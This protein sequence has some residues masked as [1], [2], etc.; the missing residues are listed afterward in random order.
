MTENSHVCKRA[1]SGA[2]HPVRRTSSM[3]SRWRLIGRIIELCDLRFGQ[4]HGWSQWAA[5]RRS[6]MSHSSPF[7]RT[8]IRYPRC[9]FRDPS[10]P[11]YRGRRAAR[12]PI[13]SATQPSPHW[14]RSMSFQTWRRTPKLRPKPRRRRGLWPEAKSSLLHLTRTANVIRSAWNGCA[15]DR[16]SNRPNVSTN[17]LR[18]EKLRPQLLELMKTMDP[19]AQAPAPEVSNRL[20]DAK[21]TIEAPGAG[22]L[23]GSVVEPSAPDEICKRDEERLE[24]L[25]SAPSLEQAE[26][27]DSELR[28]ETLRPQLRD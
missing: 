23:A 12:A 8:R 13:L 24:R 6:V 11:S 4:Q 9:L 22:P 2:P 5:S 16:R 25:R 27:F 15:A 10:S 21:T 1:H 28:C 3:P 18:C 19:L 14:R 7:P 26:R 17:E 20:A